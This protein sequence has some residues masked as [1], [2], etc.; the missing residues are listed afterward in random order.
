MSSSCSPSITP[1][2]EIRLQTIPMMSAG[3]STAFRKDPETDVNGKRIGA[4]GKGE[5]NQREKPEYIK[6]CLLL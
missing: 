6:R 4:G 1:A 2:N 5:R 3:T